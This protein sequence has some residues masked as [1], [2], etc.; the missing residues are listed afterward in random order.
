MNLGKAMGAGQGKRGASAPAPPPQL[1]GNQWE[2]S[3]EQSP[4]EEGS[5]HF[6]WSDSCLSHFWMTR[7]SHSQKI[8]AVFN[9]HPIWGGVV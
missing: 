2:P 3:L 8:S 9:S 1:L 4:R 5:R 6:P 7:Q